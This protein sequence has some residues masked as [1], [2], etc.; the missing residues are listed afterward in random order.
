MSDQTKTLPP[1]FAVL[2]LPYVLPLIITRDKSGALE[3]VIDQTGRELDSDADGAALVA[4][5]NAQPAHERCR[6]ALQHI[7]LIAD[8][9]FYGEIPI[10]ST[11]GAKVAEILSKAR[12][13]LASHNPP[14]NA[15][16]PVSVNPSPLGGRAS[17]GTKP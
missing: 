5:A 4:A 12:E 11:S 1:H 9:L 14:P 8:S 2:P 6:E 15:Q 7:T 13:A 16:S 10:G 3:N 17:G